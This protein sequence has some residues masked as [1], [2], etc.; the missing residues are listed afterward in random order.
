[1]TAKEEQVHSQFTLLPM[2]KVLIALD[3]DPTAQKVAEI[4]YSLSKTMNAELYL[5]HVVAE[6]SYYSSLD[7]SPIMGFTGFSNLDPALTINVE[8]VKRVSLDFLEQTKLHLGDENIRTVVAEGD[9]AHNIIE[10]AKSL[11]VDLIVMGTLSKKWLEK[12]IMGSVAE[13]VLKHSP[14]PM[15]IIPTWGLAEKKS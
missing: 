1:M 5:L 7:Y 14:I 3:Y 11:K 12:V 2:Q 8:E 6:N 13:N 15:L 10:V 4:G 9:S